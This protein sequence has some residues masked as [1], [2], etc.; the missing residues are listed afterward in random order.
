MAEL[1]FGIDIGTTSVSGVAVDASGAV[2]ASANRAHL[3][4]LPET[5]PGVR[6]Q[7]PAK[8]VAAVDAVIEDLERAAGA[9]AAIGWTG[10]MH[11]VVGVDADLRPVTPFVTWRDARR[12][13]GVVMTGWA[14]EGR[15]IAAC[16][17]AP[18]LA[19]AHREGRAVIDGT[20]LHAWYLDMPGVSVPAAW[21]PPRDESVMLGDNQ[22]GVVAARRL[23]P[24]CAVVN[25][26]TSGQLSVVRDV[27]FAGPAVPGESA[28]DGSRTE[29]RPYPG[30]RTLV[31]RASLVGGR[32]FADLREELGLSWDEMNAT[33]D[34]RV[35]GCVNRIVGDLVGDIDLSD[36]SALVGVGNGLVR[37]PALKAAVERRFERACTIPTVPELAAYGAA[38][39]RV[40][41]G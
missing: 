19:I 10:Q 1:T 34:P 3:A 33:D 7:D 39:H 6:E 31:C 11:G 23:V 18:S 25:L 32:A 9:A 13:G 12:F 4:D 15:A 17:A 26:G 14:K 5:A 2:V 24:G 29:L 16:L 21:I 30:G 20:F 36:V 38:I 28:A 22:A 35:V 41:Q 8:L 37:N 27:P 40:S